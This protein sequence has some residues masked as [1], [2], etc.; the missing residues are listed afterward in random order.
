MEA[1]IY[2][3]IGL[4]CG[5]VATW[6]IMH[7][8]KKNVE[9]TLMLTAQQLNQEETKTAE[10]KQQVDNVN[11]ERQ[12]L[13]DQVVKITIE[14]ERAN[15]L[16][17]AE[18]EHNEKETQLRN[19]QFNQQL[20]TVQEQFANLANQTLQQT[21]SKL[22]DANIESMQHLTKPLQENL[23]KLSLA[24][25]ATNT[26]TAKYSA[27]LSEQ[28]KQM[29]EQTLK[30]DQTATRLTNVI[31]G[32]NKQQ[33]VWGER[34]LTDI[35]DAQGLR[36]GFDYDTQHTLTD[37]KGNIILNDETGK[38]MI[39]D[40]V[41]HYPH[42][43]DVIIDAKMSIDAYYQYMNTDDQLQKDIF[44]DALAKSIRT[45]MTNL[46]KK[47]YSSFIKKPR[48]SI[49]YVIMFVPN[50][51]ALQ[52]ALATDKKLWADAFERH[53]FITGQQNLM[54]I[55][56]IIQIAWRQYAQTENQQRIYSMAEEMLKRIGEFIKRFDKVGKDIEAL[57]KDYNSA[58]EKA[59]SG[60]QS[61]VQK[62]NELKLL[63]V[64]ESANQPIPDVDTSIPESQEESTE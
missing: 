59:Y 7:L 15:T 13:Q 5:V 3:F 58:Y 44:A 22:K 17:Q 6:L 34:M 49:D 50:E 25:N 63:G 16:L 26:E 57:H 30:I 2:L 60:R 52:L 38:R 4:V 43:E 51:G 27:S 46:A 54:A 12:N 14:L 19:E 56:R 28:I 39:P 41:L 45:Q 33:G 18:Q 55:L 37:D 9:Q 23:E 47:D 36:Q 40:V 35:L 53:V 21:Q 20:K 8:R 48:Q 10:L 64:R 24:I 31:R 61:V 11:N 32:G 42:N 62:A 1:L 29:A